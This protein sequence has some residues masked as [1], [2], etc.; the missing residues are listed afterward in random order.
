MTAVSALC[1]L[2]AAQAAEMQIAGDAAREM[3]FGNVELVPEKVRG[4]RRGGLC[5]E[6]DPLASPLHG[7]H[8]LLPA[9][10]ASPRARRRSHRQAARNTRPHVLPPAHAL[11]ACLARPPRRAQGEEKQ[12]VSEM[13]VARGFATVIKHRTDE[14]RSGVY[15]RL[16]ACEEL[17]RS[18]KR[19]VHSAKEPPANRVNDVSTP[20]SA[21]RAKQYLPFFQRAGAGR[22]GAAL[23]VVLCSGAKAK[24]S[25][26]WA[27]A[28]CGRLVDG[29]P[30]GAAGPRA[31]RA[32]PP[33]PRH[34]ALPSCSPPGLRRVQPRSLTAR[35]AHSPARQ[36]DGHC[37]VRAVGPPPARAHPQGGRHDCLCA[38]RHQDALARPGA[39]PQQLPARMNAAATC[40]REW[41]ACRGPSCTLRAE[42][43]ARGTRA[44]AE[45]ERRTTCSPPSARSPPATASPQCRCVHRPAAGTSAAPRMPQA[46]R[47][48]AQLPG[49][50]S[51]IPSNISRL[52]RSPRRR[53]PVWLQGE[54]YADEALA[55]T[56]EHMMQRDVEVRARVG[57]CTQRCLHWTRRG[58]ASVAWPGR[59][60]GEKAASSPATTCL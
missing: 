46:S 25:R 27:A 30:R 23:G 24:R 3:A 47:T 41:A 52:R 18:S 58:C 13:A 38:Q 60:A 48:T 55:F 12:N 20:G 2:V 6:Q 28:P 14:E 37:G 56:R 26:G 35:A 44:R 10:A 36:D 34:G 33:A 21:T 32:A 17:A 29:D 31:V 8:A 54:P 4:E 59:D 16:V 22:G 39:T 7:A 45:V 19:G 40:T 49:P 50:R 1:A 53:A 9:D 57:H 11:P 42:H 51:R 15:E 5:P 43:V